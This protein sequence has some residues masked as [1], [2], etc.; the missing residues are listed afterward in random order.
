MVCGCLS[1]WA[2]N[3]FVQDELLMPWRACVSSRACILPDGADGQDN[4]IGLRK[5]CAPGPSG[6]CHR[7]DQSALSILLYDAF[8]RSARYVHNTTVGAES[9]R[10]GRRESRAQGGSR[11]ALP[12]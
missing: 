10:M 6:H 3:R 12:F 7:G 1:L 2:N 8:N 5:T 11:R 4:G 9:W